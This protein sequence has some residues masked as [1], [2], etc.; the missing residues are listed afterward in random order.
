MWYMLG[1][2]AGSTVVAVQIIL[3]PPG[4]G[5]PWRYNLASRELSP[6]CYRQVMKSIINEKLIKDTFSTVVY[7]SANFADDKSETMKNVEMRAASHS[8]P[9]SYVGNLYLYLFLSL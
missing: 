3:D 6:R 8:K 9:K 2:R 1:E 7:K 4:M 5:G